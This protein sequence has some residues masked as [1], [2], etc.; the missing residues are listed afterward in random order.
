MAD[1]IVFSKVKEALGLD[2][3]RLCGTAAAPISK[4][5]LEYFLSI[6]IPI[7]EI[8]GMSE[9][10]GPQTVNHPGKYIMPYTSYNKENGKLVLAD[11]LCLELN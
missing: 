9:C 7:F 6:N 4:E 2:R 5:T 8:Y 3:A 10:T 1:K 11:L